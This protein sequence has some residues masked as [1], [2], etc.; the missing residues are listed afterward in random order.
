MEFPQKKMELLYNPAISFLGIYPKELKAVSQ[1]YLHTY[2]HR[3][4]T[5]KTQ[6]VEVIQMFMLNEWINTHSYTHTQ[7]GILFNLTKE[8]TPTI[9]YNGNESR[10]HCYDI[11]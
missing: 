1:R 6:G 2:V 4:T 7:S 10:G 8:G 3:S 11:Y 5:H 9:C